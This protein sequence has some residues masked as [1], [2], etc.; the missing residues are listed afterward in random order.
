ML[1]QVAFCIKTKVLRCHLVTPFD[2]ALRI[3]PHHAIGRSL[4]A[5]SEQE[6]GGT[7]QLLIAEFADAGVGQANAF[8][9][10]VATPSG[11]LVAIPS[12]YSEVLLLIPDAGTVAPASVLLS[13]FFNK[14]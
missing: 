2:A 1:Q 4:L 10:M 9:G 7:F 13:P 3:E 14:R 12:N 11:I 5:V 8:G 6:D